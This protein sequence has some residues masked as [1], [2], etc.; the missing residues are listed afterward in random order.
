MA[1][2]SLVLACWSPVAAIANN[3]VDA[4]KDAILAE[5][6]KR[7]EQSGPDEA[8]TRRAQVALTNMG[9]LGPRVQA[10]ESILLGE[11]A[12][13]RGDALAG[14][15]A[16]VLVI[17]GPHE[18]RVVESL[19]AEG[20]ISKSRATAVY[21]VFANV[22]LARSGWTPSQA[23]GSNELRVGA[24]NARR[25]APSQPWQPRVNLQVLKNHHVLQVD[26]V[27]RALDDDNASINAI[28][29]DFLQDANLSQSD[30]S[31][32]APF[33]LD[34]E[35]PVVRPSLSQVLR[36]H[37]HNPPSV[38]SVIMASYNDKQ[39]RQAVQ[40]YLARTKLERDSSVQTVLKDLSNPQATERRAA[41]DILAQ[42]RTSQ[43]QVL[44]ALAVTEGTDPAAGVREA[45]FQTWNKLLK[46]A[47]TV[48]AHSSAQTEERHAKVFPTVAGILR[49]GRTSERLRFAAMSYLLAMRVDILDLLD[50]Y[51]AGLLRP[52]G[53]EECSLGEAGVRRALQS[54][55]PSV[56]NVLWKALHDSNKEAIANLERVLREDPAGLRVWAVALAKGASAERKRTLQVV[57]NRD[58]RT[59]VVPPLSYGFIPTTDPRG[60]PRPALCPPLPNPFGGET[61]GKDLICAVVD[62]AADA[63][64]D[65][66]VEAVRTLASLVG[67]GLRHSYSRADPATEAQAREVVVAAIDDSDAGVR[68]A[69]LSC[70]VQPDGGA[71]CG[72]AAV[73]LAQRVQTEEGRRMA[74]A[75][76]ALA[77][78][79][80]RSDRRSFETLPGFKATL[81]DAVWDKDARIREP[82]RKIWAQVYFRE[83]LP[84]PPGWWF[85]RLL[86][87]L[88]GISCLALAALAGWGAARLHQPCLAAGPRQ[89]ALAAAGRTACGTG[90]ILAVGGLTI[91]GLAAWESQGRIGSAL[92]VLGL[93]IVLATLLDGLAFIAWG[94]QVRSGRT[95][96]VVLVTVLACGS[97]LYC[98]LS[99]ATR[100]LTCATA[101]FRLAEQGII[102]YLII[103]GTVAVGGICVLVNILRAWSTHRTE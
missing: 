5:L 81:G 43:M 62:C 34:T 65:V 92:G 97:T 93:L 87:A 48:P 6:L 85:V 30:W 75:W 49:D 56:G 50:L 67:E 33:L 99:C 27:R 103:D 80:C 2:A 66:R 64:P 35:K 68:E 101:G 17:I 22:D 88:T 20:R 3:P 96:D 89:R 15:I 12:G 36:D 11:L 41:A 37:G 72:R 31:T 61:L 51:L 90:A 58:Y 74:L 70:L 21:H 28:A 55:R 73:A 60:R 38:E 94:L 8:G 44:Q 84:S 59:K 102:G 54:D 19:A 10:A 77:E 52:Q 95:L 45:A 83:E 1:F 69:A 91:M 42:S 53:S 47:A 71:L 29:I 16:H 100:L 76:A 46:D 14:S 32:L 24:R 82:A 7:V 78:A 13:S 18:R 63:D 25:T 57:G 86:A 4:V 79:S 23:P 40:H 9:W 98:G 39:L 26:D